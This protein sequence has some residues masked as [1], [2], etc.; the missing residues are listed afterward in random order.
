MAHWK[1]SLLE[2]P[3][4]AYLFLARDR[5]FAAYALGC[6]GVEQWP[7]C[8]ALLASDG[9]GEKAIYLLSQPLEGATMLFLMGEEEAVRA[10]FQQPMAAVPFAWIHAQDELLGCLKKYWRLESQEKM[11]RLVVGR[12]NFKLPENSAGS[13]LRRLRSSDGEALSEAYETAFGI[14]AA[15]RLL[16]RGPYYGVWEKGELV[17]VAGT[18]LLSSR[19]GAAAVGNVWTRPSHRGRGL[20]T[21]TVGAVTQELLGY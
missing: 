16:E 21:L 11:L 2:S 14:P 9:E 1:V 17:S 13:G 3:E 6:L 10:V 19:Y 18:H 12:K 20:G 7:F 8:T 5:H 15:S 4:E